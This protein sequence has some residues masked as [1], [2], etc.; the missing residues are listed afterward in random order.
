[1]LGLKIMLL[2]GRANCAADLTLSRAVPLLGC[3]VQ[4]VKFYFH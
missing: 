3:A 2:L 1:M 4:N